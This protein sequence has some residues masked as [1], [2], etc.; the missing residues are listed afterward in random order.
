MLG[1][2]GRVTVERVSET[3][4]QSERVP[5]VRTLEV[6][7]GAFG[8]TKEEL[9]ADGVVAGVVDMLREGVVGI[10]GAEARVDGVREGVEGGRVLVCF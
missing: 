1:T 2:E 4:D 6:E 8:M 7:P 5:D 9:L 10:A 3:S